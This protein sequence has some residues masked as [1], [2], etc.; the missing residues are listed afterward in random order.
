M[1]IKLGEEQLQKLYS[2]ILSLKTEKQCADFFEDLCTVSELLSMGQRYHVATLLSKGVV[3]TEIVNETGAS[4]ATISRVNK[5][6]QH[7][8]GGYK[9]VLSGNEGV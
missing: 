7:G 8:S 5:S 2:A 1:N 6:L 4:T 3:F 9:S